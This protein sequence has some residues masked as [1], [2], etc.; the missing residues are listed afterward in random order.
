MDNKRRK[1]RTTTSQALWLASR[2]W[3]SGD[4]PLDRNVLGRC[5][6]ARQQ[7][8][9]HRPEQPHRWELTGVLF[10]FLLQRATIFDVSQRYCVILRN[11]YNVQ[12]WSRAEWHNSVRCSHENDC[13]AQEHDCQHLYQGHYT[14]LY[15]LPLS[16]YGAIH[17]TFSANITPQ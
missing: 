16:H 1:R 7:R 4:V 2:E 14:T 9:N 5:R 17:L 13:I 6:R 3:C 12:M 8:G 15:L 11:M 10:F